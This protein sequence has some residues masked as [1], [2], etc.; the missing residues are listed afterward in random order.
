MDALSPPPL[1]APITADAKIAAKELPIGVL[2][3]DQSKA[4]LLAPA[5]KG[6]PVWQEQQLEAL[7]LC[8]L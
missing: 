1:E 5:A 7:R 2:D 3:A 6:Q 4:R 8:C